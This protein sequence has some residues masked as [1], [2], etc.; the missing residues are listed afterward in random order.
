MCTHA[1]LKMTKSEKQ[2]FKISFLTY[3]IDSESSN[4]FQWEITL[5]VFTPGMHCSFKVIIL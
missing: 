4:H 1:V 3:F 5:Q 2:V